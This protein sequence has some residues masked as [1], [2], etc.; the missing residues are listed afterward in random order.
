MSRMPLLAASLLVVAASHAGADVITNQN[1]DVTLT[2]GSDPDVGLTL[3]SIAY[4]GQTNPFLL[5]DAGW[6][7]AGIWELEFCNPSLSPKQPFTVRPEDCTFNYS[8]L[9]SSPPNGFVATW[10]NVQHPSVG[11]HFSVQVFATAPN[12]D[13]VIKFHIEVNNQSPDRSL[14]ALSFPVTRIRELPDPGSSQRLFLP[15]AAGYEFRDPT[16]NP[17]VLYDDH[18]PAHHTILPLM[19]PSG[20]FTMQYFSYYGV[21]AVATDVLFGGTRDTTGHHKEYIFD[22]NLEELDHN[23]LL[24]AIR[25]LPEYNV[26]VGNDFYADNSFV[27]TAFEGNGRS[28]WYDAAQVYREWATAQQW[29]DGRTP[30][31]IVDNPEFSTIIRDAKM[32][33]T[34]SLADPLDTTDFPYWSRDVEHQ[35]TYFG[36]DSLPGNI[37]FWHH[38][39]A[40]SVGA[41]GDWWPANSDFLT[42]VQQDIH[43]LGHEFSPYFYNLCYATD[44]RS[45]LRSYVPGYGSVAPYTVMNEDGGHDPGAGVNSRKLCQS[46]DFARDYTIECARRMV[47]GFGASGIYLDGFTAIA[48][49]LCYDPNHLHPPGGGDSRTLAKMELLEDL[50]A[51]MRGSY[52]CEEYFVRSEGQNEM[53]VGLV[54][55]TYANYFHNYELYLQLLGGNWGAQVPAYPAVWG[56]YQLTTYPSHMHMQLTFTPEEYRVVRRWVAAFSHFGYSL[57]SGSQ[58]GSLTM[59]DQM[60]AVPGYEPFI[61]M[62]QAYMAVLKL[63]AVRE[64][65]TFGIRLRDPFTNAEMVD[66]LPGD[67]FLPLNLRSQP[68]VYT[69]AHRN[70]DGDGFGLLLLN[71]TID[72]ET[73]AAGGSTVA[74]GDQ[75]IQYTLDLADYGMRTGLYRKTVYFSSGA[76]A[77]TDV[78]LGALY[79]STQTV[80]ESSAVF[81]SFER[82]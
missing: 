27:L 37:Y 14:Y 50:R 19:C 17:F 61:E 42:E 58:L 72:G 51:A 33:G 65:Q 68:V 11:G 36:V 54:E 28:P 81:I 78:N 3:E 44:I 21:S 30:L 15:I 62:V 71:W 49:N 45:Y 24:S 47:Q 35:R 16:E 76:T 60:A 6:P 1:Q 7:D 41:S 70:Q 38:H 57:W 18:D 74:G 79:T 13:S 63:D 22:A 10:S 32:I 73:Y 48:P 23:Y 29:G 12:D 77:Q 82:L 26:T 4:Q 56:D 55:C 2:Y 39:R 53:Y 43:P 67:G 64:Y 40:G 25:Y 46:T 69:S 20:R 8:V 5:T 80:E 66:E 52:G 34:T 9:A 75:D 31:P 59:F